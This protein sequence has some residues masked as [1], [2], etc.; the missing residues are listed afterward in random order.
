MTLRAIIIAELNRTPKPTGHFP[1]L[2]AVAIAPQAGRQLSN[3]KPIQNPFKEP[4]PNMN[5][6]YD[7]CWASSSLPYCARTDE[8]TNGREIGWRRAHCHR[9]CQKRFHFSN[10][11]SRSSAAAANS[12]GLGDSISAPYN[13]SVLQIILPYRERQK[14]VQFARQPA[15]VPLV[16]KARKLDTAQNRLP[17]ERATIQT[18]LL[19]PLAGSNVSG[20]ESF[21]FSE[22]WEAIFLARFTSYGE[23]SWPIFLAVGKLVISF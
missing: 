2:F 17:R 10:T 20:T 14:R 3:L 19:M 11:G 15:C 6:T 21:T 16:I 8:L 18:T 23:F 12:Q 22:Q 5:L 13:M 1:I 7:L 4:H 9:E